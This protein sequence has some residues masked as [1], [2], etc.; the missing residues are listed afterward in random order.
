MT[1]EHVPPRITFN[2]TTRYKE[3]PFLEHLQSEDPLSIP[4]KGKLHQGGVGYYS[5]CRDCNSYLG[6]AFVPAFNAYSNSFI[7]LAKRTASNYFEIEMHDFE[8]LKVLKQTIAMFL[9]MNSV[10][11]SKNNHELSNFLLDKQSNYIP[12][13]YRVF[14]YLN[15]EGQ[16][17]NIPIMVT[18]NLETG[19]SIAAT[20]IA[21]PPLGHVLT[22]NFNGNLPFHHE[23]TDFKH[24]A[25]GEKG[26]KFLKS[27]DCQ[28]FYLFCWTIERKMLSKKQLMNLANQLALECSTH[29]FASCGLM[30]LG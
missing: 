17:R 30:N 16:L 18:G 5:F 21:F 9:A 26:L 7:E 22:I 8:V 28:R 12:E 20:E 10:D 6:Q 27:S 4:S 29:G 19:S 24:T 1:F 14:I 11:F 3:I 13:K 2:K 23:I 15:S 25:L